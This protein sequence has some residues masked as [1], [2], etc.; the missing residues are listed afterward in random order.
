MTNKLIIW[1]SDGKILI[2]FLSLG[3]HI[4]TITYETNLEF[5]RFM[6][7][8]V[9]KLAGSRELKSWCVNNPGKMLLDKM[10]ARD[11]AYSILCYKNGIDV[12]MELFRMK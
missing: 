12:W 5:L 1:S 11:I 10:T 4:T 2:T 6:D 7:F 9:S 8:Y 3:P